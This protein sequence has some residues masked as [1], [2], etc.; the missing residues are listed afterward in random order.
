MSP[1]PKRD[2]KW[3]WGWAISANVTHRYLLTWERKGVVFAEVEP[4][5]PAGL[6]GLRHG[7]VTEEVRPSASGK[8]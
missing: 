1:S 7:A 5:R 8:R 3:E 2:S 4:G 6:V